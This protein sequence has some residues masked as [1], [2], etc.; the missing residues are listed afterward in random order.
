MFDDLCLILIAIVGASGFK[1]SL[2]AGLPVMMLL[3]GLMFTACVFWM[4][5]RSGRNS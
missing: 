3:C 4:G 2:D 5:A 1:L